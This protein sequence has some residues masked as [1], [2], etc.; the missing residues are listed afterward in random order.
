M[1]QRPQYLLAAFARVGHPVYFVDPREPTVR[2]KDN[3]TI[4]P[5]LKEVPGSHVILYVHFA[6]IGVLF[7]RFEDAAVVYD[8]LDDLTIYDADEA[9][10]P[11]ERRVRSHH[12]TVMERADVV[13]ASAPELIETHRS[14]RQGILL[15]ENG[16]EPSRFQGDPATPTMLADI[17][18]PIIGYHGAVAR[19]FDFDLMRGVA[20]RLPRHEFVMVGP[21]E[22][23]VEASMDV[24]VRLPNVHR[25]GAVSSDDIPS[26][27][28]G[29]DVGVI[30][31]VV[32]DLTRAVSPLKMYEYL[33]AQVPVV[34]TPL[35]VCVGHPVVRTAS[36][37]DDFA[38]AI[39]AAEQERHTELFT[40]AAR[41]ATNEASWD[42]RIE[43]VRQQLA[44]MDLLR[45]PS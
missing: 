7:D 15:V 37:A 23:D 27:V 24:L 42:S 32:D 30:P 4:V 3:V 34:A 28:A 14:E 33:A 21:V 22:P 8:I 16:V 45:V 19:W 11:E 12:P 41:A 43:I 6:P 35:P 10:M 20:E 31:F 17:G 1:R 25:L 36:T 40:T 44:E 9:G 26:Y 18:R 39:V 38:A 29:F 5:S 2:H 13:I